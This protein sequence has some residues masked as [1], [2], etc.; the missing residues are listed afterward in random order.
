MD[1]VTISLQFLQSNCL[2]MINLIPVQ[3]DFLGTG[4]DAA[5]FVRIVEDVMVFVLAH[6]QHTV[7]VGD[8]GE[9]F[10]GIQEFPNGA[11]DGFPQVDGVPED[12][13]HPVFQVGVHEIL[14]IFA[15]FVDDFVFVTDDLL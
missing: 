5:V 13:W 4:N 7:L 9:V 15:G 1:Y 11:D 10:A 8:P 2:L 14:K 6:Q 3:D 12:D